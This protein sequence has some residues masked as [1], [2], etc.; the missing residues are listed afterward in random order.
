MK[1]QEISEY[2]NQAERTQIEKDIVEE[3]GENPK[4]LQLNLQQYSDQKH[5]DWLQSPSGNIYRFINYNLFTILEVL[6][7]MDNV[8]KQ[9]KKEKQFDYNNEN[10]AWKRCFKAH[11][12]HEDSTAIHCFSRIAGPEDLSILRIDGIQEKYNTWRKMEALNNPDHFYNS[13]NEDIIEA[14]K[15]FIEANFTEPKEMKFLDFFYHSANE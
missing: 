6:V 12:S 4:E 15:M 7:D 14:F 9:R 10:Y 11:F 8:G 1:Q 13:E 5:G 2:L 3:I